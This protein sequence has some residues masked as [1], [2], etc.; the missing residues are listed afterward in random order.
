MSR[1]HDGVEPIEH[2][3]EGLWIMK[4]TMNYLNQVKSGKF[5]HML[6]DK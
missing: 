6:N 5:N 2:L 3:N 1:I 4:D